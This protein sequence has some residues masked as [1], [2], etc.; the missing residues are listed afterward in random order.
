MPR[1][2][3][4]R[5]RFYPTDEQAQQLARQFGCVRYAY[6]AALAHK[7]EA[8]RERAEKVPYAE[9]DR[10]LT[11]MKREPETAFLAEV[12]STPLQHALRQLDKAY[13]AFFQG[14][15]K[16]P[17]FQSRRHRQSATYTYKAFSLKGSGT[18]GQPLVKLG[19]QSEP[20]DIRWG[21]GRSFRP[22]LSVPKTLTVVCRKPRRRA[23]TFV[24]AGST[25][26]SR[27]SS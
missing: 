1:A 8:F 4:L 6:N 10:R 27:M 23:R 17:R 19:K 16:Y 20:L 18:E 2:A 15:A 12:S 11:R 24:R 7:A 22:L 5:Y 13:T 9:T 26:G 21:S 25:S 14:N 3:R